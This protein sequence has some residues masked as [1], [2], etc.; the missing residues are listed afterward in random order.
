MRMCSKSWSFDFTDASSPSPVGFLV[1][2]SHFSGVVTMI[3]VCAISDFVN[4]MSPCIFR[5]TKIHTKSMHTSQFADFYGQPLQ[6]FSKFPNNFWRQC[7][8]WCTNSGWSKKARIEYD[9]TYTYIIL[10]ESRLIVDL[11]WGSI[12]DFVR[13][14]SMT[15]R[16]VSIATSVFP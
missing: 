9:I 15:R 16:M 4:C 6:P 5:Y 8:H 7:F 11:I 13:C 2:T 3:C 12:D 10:K 14:W 1:T